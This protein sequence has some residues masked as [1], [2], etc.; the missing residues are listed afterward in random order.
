L[1]L[2]SLG[3]EDLTE[4]RLNQAVEALVRAHPEQYLIWG[5]NRYKKVSSRRRRGTYAGRRRPR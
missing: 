5:Y 3:T 1:L 2:D 4:E